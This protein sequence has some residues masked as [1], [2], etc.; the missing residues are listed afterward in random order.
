MH[1]LR[2]GLDGQPKGW[3]DSPTM[4]GISTDTKHCTKRQFEQALA[5]EYPGLDF[6][7]EQRAVAGG[8][9]DWLA[10]PAR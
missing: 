10:G 4:F 1:C 8:G 9:A 2:D 7:I 3:M 6:A 5:R